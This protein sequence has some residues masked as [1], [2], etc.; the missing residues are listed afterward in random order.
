MVVAVVAADLAAPVVVEA[1]VM[2][3]ERNWCE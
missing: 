2:T 1:A 3:V